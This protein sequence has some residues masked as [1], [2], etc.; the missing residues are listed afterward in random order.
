MLSWVCLLLF[1]SLET[2]HIWD[3]LAFHKIHPI[4]FLIRKMLTFFSNQEQ[5]RLSKIDFHYSRNHEYQL[6]ERKRL[7]NAVPSID[8]DAAWAQ[9]MYLSFFI[10][11]AAT[12]VPSPT[13]SDWY[14]PPAQWSLSEVIYT[15]IK[16]PV[17]DSK[18]AIALLSL[19]QFQ[20]HFWGNCG[21]GN[22]WEKSREQKV[23][24]IHK[25]PPGNSLTL[26]SWL[27]NSGRGS[28]GWIGALRVW[29]RFRGS[30][31]PSNQLRV[32]PH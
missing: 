8:C 6:L 32:S 31:F 30:I 22:L 4:W 21:G 5:K 13:Y 2:P 24:N 17:T 27:F 18:T 20:S 25:K 1:W 16:P 9:N 23:N 28:Q 15:S 26:K 19:G 29:K 12:L 3:M 10:S 11:T 14:K 7:E